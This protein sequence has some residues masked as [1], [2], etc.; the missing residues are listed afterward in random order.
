MVEIPDHILRNTLKDLD[1]EKRLGEQPHV[2]AAV[3]NASTNLL[4]NII[5]VDHRGTLI[6]DGMIIVTDIPMVKR[7]ISQKQQELIDRMKDKDPDYQPPSLTVEIPLIVGVTRWSE[8]LGLH[9]PDLPIPED[10]IS[11]HVDP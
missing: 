11:F 4:E 3:I 2:R 10:G 9:N 8:E 5:V 7:Q 1:I 6:I